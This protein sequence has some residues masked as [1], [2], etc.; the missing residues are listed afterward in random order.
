MRYLHKIQLI[1][2]HTVGIA[3]TTITTA[4][5]LMPFSDGFAKKV[6]AA[7]INLR[8]SGSGTDRKKK[9]NE[10]PLRAWHAFDAKLAGRKQANGRKRFARIRVAVKL[11]EK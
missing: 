4:Y 5:N 1:S 10:P 6:A 3:A 9:T 11:F 2:S 7:H 8:Y